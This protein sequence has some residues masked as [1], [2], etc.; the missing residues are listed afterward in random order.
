MFLSNQTGSFQTTAFGFRGGKTPPTPHPPAAL[1]QK[2]LKS[3]AVIVGY[4]GPSCVS[5]KRA[6][7]TTLFPLLIKM[8]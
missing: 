5:F 4:L 1:K 6:P 8:H 7:A 2:Q 3:N